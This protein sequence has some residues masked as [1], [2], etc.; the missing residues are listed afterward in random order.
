MVRIGLMASR[1]SPIDRRDFLTLA[2]AAALGASLG[3]ANAAGAGL[4]LALR[5]KTG[6]L[7]LRSGQAATPIWLLG[8]PSQ[9]LRFKRG[10]ALE[11]GLQSDLPSPILMNWHGLDG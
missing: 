5:A 10:G 11:V 7:A 8:A 1:F 6:S 2:G 3:A 9:P 4:P